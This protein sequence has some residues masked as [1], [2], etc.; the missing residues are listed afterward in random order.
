[1]N[2]SKKIMNQQNSD[3]EKKSNTVAKAATSKT[4]LGKSSGRNVKAIVWSAICIVLVL[5][6]CIG[7]GIQQFKPQ[8]AFSV[9]GT[10]ITMDDMM[11]PIYVKESTYLPYDEMYQAYMGTSV[12]DVTYQGSDTSVPSG[13]SNK[14]GIKQE[15]LDEEEAYEVLYQEAK[16]AG[17]KLSSDDEKKVEKNVTQARKGL[18][19]VQKL[20]L[21]MSKKNLTK[22][23]EKTVLADKF[24]SD[25]QKELNKGVDKDS[26]IKKISK[27]DYREYDVQYYAVP[28]SKTDSNGNTKQ[29]S[30]AKKK[31]YETEIKKL[32]KKAATA[33]DFTKLI[34]S[35]DKT[36]ITYNKA[37]FTEKDG[38]SYLSAANLK[39][40]KAMKN[41]TISQV[42]LDEK[43]GYYV[44]VKM[45]D[46]NSTSSYQKA[47]DSAVTSAQ[48]EK[49][50][51]WYEKL[52]ET[53][54]I[55]VNASVWNDVTIGTMTTEIVTADDLQKMSKESSSSKKSSS[56]K[57]SSSSSSEK[58]SS[59]ESSSSSSSK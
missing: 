39:K 10:K 24:K 55:N 14:I 44:F 5:V 40:V 50:N 32:A 28:L 1:M 43:A 41:G 15:V 58:S 3:S 49:Y 25:K 59:S 42:F 6:L 23:F 20:R 34:G 13:I 11:Y 56:S 52:K 30:D 4:R 9:N 53:Y 57:S 26:V 8:V 27:K 51:K 31:S 35:K 38:W 29:V 45:I 48:T 36:D 2:S 46:N 22:R 16:K 12:W 54:K 19:W 37:E 18:T 17:Y 47:C 33:K 21:S 7:V